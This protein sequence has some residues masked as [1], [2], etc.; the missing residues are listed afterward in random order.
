MCLMGCL[1]AESKLSKLKCSESEEAAKNTK[2]LTLTILT[3]LVGC[4]REESNS[5]S[6]TVRDTSSL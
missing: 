3:C 5:V 1:R 6:V 2:R 4:L